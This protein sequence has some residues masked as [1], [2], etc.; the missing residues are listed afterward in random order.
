[1]ITIYIIGS[2]IIG[3]LAGIYCKRLLDRRRPQRQRTINVIWAD[4]INGNDVNFLRNQIDLALADPD[5]HI[6]TNYPVSWTS[7]PVNN[8]SE[9]R[10][11]SR[12]PN[13]SGILEQLQ[14]RWSADTTSS[15]YLDHAFSDSTA[16]RN[17]STAWYTPSDSDSTAIHHHKNSNRRKPGV[18][19]EAFVLRSRY[20]MVRNKNEKNR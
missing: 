18:R 11:D 1:M 4:G 15:S 2:I 20:D 14:N 12:N 8:E 9:I 5:Y 6:I 19:S 7:I 17:D 3:A 10:V 16:S 13:S